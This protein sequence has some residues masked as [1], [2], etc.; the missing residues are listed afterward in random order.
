M[1]LICNR[2][3]AGAGGLGSFCNR[4]GGRAGADENGGAEGDSTAE[5]R[6]RREK[7]SH[8]AVRDWVGGLF[9]RSSG[10]EAAEGSCGFAR[11]SLGRRGR[12][13][14]DL[15]SGCRARR[16]FV[17]EF[18]EIGENGSRAGETLGFFF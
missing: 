9:E 15:T 5:T 2:G 16:W 8:F 14:R 13:G 7:T 11:C 3:F 12:A 6:R 1:G 18:G 17:V 10:A 4:E